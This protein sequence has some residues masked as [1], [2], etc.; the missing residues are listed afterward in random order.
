MINCRN[1]YL[2]PHE[3]HVITQTSFAGPMPS[4]LS[5]LEHIFSNF[6]GLPTSHSQLLKISFNSPVALLIFVLRKNFDFKLSSQ[7]K[8]FLHVMGQIIFAGFKLPK[9]TDFLQILLIFFCFFPD[10]HEQVFCC[11]TWFPVS[12]TFLIPFKKVAELSSMQGTDGLVDGG[13]VRL[14]SSEGPLE[15]GTDGE[16]VGDDWVNPLHTPF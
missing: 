16:S 6:D 15:G 9:V 1:I 12:S 8:H 14:F 3:L 2:H 13:L 7:G 5:V 10:S 11:A 4:L